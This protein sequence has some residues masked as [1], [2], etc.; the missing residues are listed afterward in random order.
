MTDLNTLIAMA[1]ELNASDVHIVSGLPVR[2]RVDGSIRNLTEELLTFEDCENYGRAM[3]GPRFS[4]IEEMGELDLAQ[5]FPCVPES[6][7]SGSR[8]VSPPPFV[9]WQSGFRSWR[10]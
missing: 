9:C 5:S 4:E 1:K 8:A 3:A 2:C 7:C 6:T 10:S